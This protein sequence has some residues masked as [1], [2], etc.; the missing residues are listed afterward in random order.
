MQT[1]AYHRESLLCVAV[2][3]YYEFTPRALYTDTR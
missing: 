1:L 2:Q 3:N